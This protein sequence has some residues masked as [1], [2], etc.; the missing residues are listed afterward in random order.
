MTTP[1]SKKFWDTVL[2]TV[3]ISKL[4]DQI[5][6]EQ[7]ELGDEGAAEELAR[8]SAARVQGYLEQA[9]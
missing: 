5:L 3:P 7:A 6:R 4:P 9:D 8:R 1:P 2:D